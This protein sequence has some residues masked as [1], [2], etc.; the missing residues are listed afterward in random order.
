MAKTMS[1]EIPF[2][3]I[4]QLH[5]SLRKQANISSYN[6]DDPSIPNLPIASQTISELDPSSPNLRCTKCN[7]RLLRGDLSVVCV[8]C[9]KQL[10]QQQSQEDKK[11]SVE[12]IHF[13]STLGCKWLFESLNL[14]GISSHN[15]NATTSLHDST[16]CSGVDYV[17]VPVLSNSIA[18][19]LLKL[20]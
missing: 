16:A 19:S 1:F 2:D 18:H 9:G 15:V 10:P 11:L 3:L 20:A 13:K 8:F 14:D 12:A 17:C 7:G 5:I 6:P 4:H